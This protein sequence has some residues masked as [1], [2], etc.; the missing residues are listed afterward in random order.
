MALDPEYA[1]RSERF[2][3]LARAKAE[4]D[5]ELPTW[6]E[7]ELAD[8]ERLHTAPVKTGADLLRV[9]MAVLSDIQ[10][11]LDKGDVTS[12]PLLQKAGDEDEIRNYLVEQMNYRSRSRF[13]AYREAQVAN[14]DRPDVIIASTAAPCEVG[15]EIKHGGKKW[16]CGQLEQALR[17]QL[18]S[19]YLKPASRRHGVFVITNHG[20][21]RWRDPE[22]K[23]PMNFD[24]LVSWLASIAATIRENDS[25]PIQVRCFGINA[26]ASA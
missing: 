4:R 20:P 22:T 23:Q 14:R 19:D 16:T 1:I 15:M 11:Q 17:G 3:E 21:R 13:H 26:E 10:F 18:A 2:Q 12:R 9:V 25:G 6:S 7:R 24:K 5:S 8:F